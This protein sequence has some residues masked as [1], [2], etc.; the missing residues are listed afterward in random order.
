MG[1]QAPHCL[2]I[3]EPDWHRGVIRRGETAGLGRRWDKSKGL[4]PALV[5]TIQ[6]V[7]PLWFCACDFTAADLRNP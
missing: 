7:R 2:G 6:A 3:H 4:F 1:A 5:A